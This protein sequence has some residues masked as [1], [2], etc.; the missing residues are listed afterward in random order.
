MTKGE[1]LRIF[2]R[3]RELEVLD[4]AAASS[5]AEMIA[6]YG[7]R[8]I[9]KTYLMTN[10]FQNHTTFFT[11]T[12]VKGAENKEQLVN[13]Y[14]EL[15]TTFNLKKDDTFPAN[16]QKAFHLLTKCI[17]NIKS[18]KKIILF[19]DELPWLAKQ[20]SG[21]IRH[22]EYFWN[23]FAS[24]DSRVIV[25][26]CGSAA[27]WMISK[28]IKNKGGLYGRLTRIIKLLPFTLKET[29]EY[30]RYRKVTL[31]RRDIIDLYLCLGGVAKYLN[32][33][34]KGQ[35]AAQNINTICFSPVAGLVDEF[36][37]LFKSL[38]ENS[39]KHLK[40]VTALAKKRKGMTRDEL[41]KKCS[42]TTG[43]GLSTVLEE[44]IASGFIMKVNQF[45]N[46]RKIMTYRLIDEFSLFHLSWIK[47][48]PPLTSASQQDYWLKVS[49]QSAWKAWAGYAFEGVCI[50]HVGQIQQSLN[51]GGVY[52]E[53]SSWNYTPNSSEEQGVQIDL[54]L[55]RDDR[56][57][58]ICELK[59]VQD[60]YTVTKSAATNIRQ[61][62]S[63]FREHTG[64]KKTLF[65]TLI[66]TYGAK[67]DGNY[68]SVPIQAQLDM[69]ALFSF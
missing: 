5:E 63:T 31:E 14:E 58:N 51:I 8:R 4:G 50:K 37:N 62:I 53:A 44:L 23:Q 43:G 12:G 19:F 10:Y 21:F 26:L 57:I 41:V 40:L 69:N 17:K 16:W 47:D 35:S 48:T 36:D 3:E 64:T 15:S 56:V 55:D 38:F 25:V 60:V 33:V 45:G 29:E 1:K 9:G 18:Q 68:N 67:C 27:S 22:L 54:L 11:L 42:F 39:E 6:V 2:G 49:R 52:A 20:K 7:R 46:K 30:L 66:T 59:Y 32:Y 13:F 34:E 24:K 28:V 61:K 65:P